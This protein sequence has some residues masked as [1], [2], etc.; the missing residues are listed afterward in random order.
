MHAEAVAGSVIKSGVSL[1]EGGCIEAPEGGAGDCGVCGLSL[2]CGVRCSAPPPHAL[3][4]P[5]HSST[6]TNVPARLEMTSLRI[7]ITRYRRA[8]L[9]LARFCGYY[10][11][12]AVFQDRGRNHEGH[13]CNG[14][15]ESQPEPNA[16]GD[17]AASCPRIQI[18]KVLNISHFHDV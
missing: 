13:G 9:G 1:D 17:A 4:T 6:E 18:Y 16:G 14:E 8:R 12:P 3:I 7:A 10:V 15:N 11:E 5:A 2:A